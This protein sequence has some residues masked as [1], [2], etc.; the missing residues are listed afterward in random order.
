[1]S[2]E[3]DCVLTL[4]QWLSPGFPVGAFAYS[5][6]LEQVIEAR[7]IADAADLGDWLSALVAHGSGRAD[8][9]L[10]AAAWRATPDSLPGIDAAARAFAASSER[11]L[12]TTAQGEAFARTLDSMTGRQTEPFAYPVAVG[13]AAALHDLP[14]GLTARMYLH[15]FAANLVSAAVRRVPLGQTEG[16]MV[17]AGLAPLIRAVAQEAIASDPDDLASHCFAADIAAMHHETM[18]SRVF[19]T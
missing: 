19:R 14:L 15:A 18:Y 13:H 2:T 1:M 11:L 5:H 12:E 9:V 10:L 4:Q 3:E 8:V 6:G 17:L 16:Q 7:G